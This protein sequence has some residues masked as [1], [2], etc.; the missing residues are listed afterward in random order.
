MSGYSRADIS[1]CPLSV[2]EN[3]PY[4]RDNGRQNLTQ[5]MEDNMKKFILAMAAI[6]LVSINLPTAQAGDRALNGLLIGGGGGALLGQGIG[7][8]TE[9]TLIGATVGGVLG[10]I[11][12]NEL[13]RNLSKV[14]DHHRPR[15]EVR[16][17]HHRYPSRITHHINSSRLTLQRICTETV[18]IREGKYRDKRVVKRECRNT[19]RPE[20]HFNR[21]R[22]G[23]GF[24][25]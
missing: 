7:R 2:E 6:L 25:R 12:G 23:H 9:A 20:Q 11:V 24:Y 18:F 1:G 19:Y 15:V 8:N 14:H 4:K 3:L 10:L 13:D 16:H 22:P 5:P 17:I 21:H